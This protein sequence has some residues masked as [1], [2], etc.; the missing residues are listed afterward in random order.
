MTAGLLIALVALQLT[1]EP[2][3]IAGT[4]I[5]RG[6]AVQQPL[7]D[8]RLELTVGQGAAVVTRT[9]LNGE[10]AFPNLRPGQ[11]RLTVTSDGFIRQEYG[12]RIVVG[13]GQQAGNILFELDPAAMLA[14]RV[15]DSFGE[16]IAHVMVE[17]L[18]R[19]YDVR[20]S[21]RLAR[22]ASAL[23]D[24]RGEYRIF[25]LDP[26][27]YF[28]YASSALP[29]SKEEQPLRVVTPTYFPGVRAPD[30]AK[31]LRLDMGREIRVDFRLSRRMSLWTVSG[32]T[33]DGGTSRSIAATITLTPSAQDPSFSRHRD[34]SSA[35]GRE[36]GQF[37]ILNVVP[38]SYV[39]MAKSGSGDQ[40]LAIFESVSLR[41]VPY[42]PRTRPPEHEVSLR[43][44]PP[45]SITGRLFV[46][47]RE[48]ADLSG[49]SVALISVDPDMPSPRRVF[50]RPDGQLVLDDVVPGSYVLEISGLAHDLY[51]KA[52]RFGDDDI[53]EGPLTLDTPDAANPL[54][55]LW[56]STAAASRSRHTVMRASL[57]RR[58]SYSS[59]TSHAVLGETS[60]A[61]R[62]PAKMDRRSS[63]EFPRGATS[64]LPG[65][66]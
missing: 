47:S 13:E 23:T 26:G 55:I 51:L 11:Y 63:R 18:H 65:R 29:E 40:E 48:G 34:E 41:P 25:W 35:T 9:D 59:Q 39:L 28:F 1:P 5:K 44:A 16:P 24:D 15:L 37:S 54:G 27:E 58:T 2:G 61:S 45:F 60:I 52:A 57:T 12:K 43:L 3:T 10:F 32:Q 49:A 31:S 8:A 50:A 4:V 36:P 53:L 62:C 14:G 22:A 30:D 46:E 64:Y 42:S 33:M 56:V 6:T 19:T 7:G 66:I 21:P 17:A 20:G 38:G